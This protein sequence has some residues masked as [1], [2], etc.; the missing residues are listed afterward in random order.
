MNR[1]DAPALP[2]SLA[3]FS[4]IGAA[5]LSLSALAPRASAQWV[6]EDF[7]LKAGWNA[8]WLSIDCS[9]RPLDDPDQVAP[10]TSLLVG[11]PDIEEV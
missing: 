8:V 3:R 1:S 6:T 10:D 7:P 2:F 11:S 5:T 9:D 4:I